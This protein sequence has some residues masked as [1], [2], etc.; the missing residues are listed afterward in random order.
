MALTHPANPY[1]IK[2]SKFAQF[3]PG[4]PGLSCYSTILNLKKNSKSNNVIKQHFWPILTWYN[5][6]FFLND[7]SFHYAWNEDSMRSASWDLDNAG[8]QVGWWWWD[9]DNTGA[10]VG[11]QWW[12]SH[13]FKQYIFSADCHGVHNFQISQPLQWI[14]RTSTNVSQNKS[15]Y[16]LK[17]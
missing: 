13:K 15:L 3:S 8:G 6:P 17:N 5:F 11:W 2:N 14:N 9:L 12:T 16:I 4:Q 1:A 10:W 7:T